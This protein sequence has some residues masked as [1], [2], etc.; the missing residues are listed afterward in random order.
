[1]HYQCS[2][3]GL[4]H[5]EKRSAVECC[6]PEPFPIPDEQVVYCW[7][8]E[9]YGCEACLQRGI[10]DVREL[11]A[12]AAALLRFKEYQAAVLTDATSTA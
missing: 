8:C 12:H 3:C 4:I 1:M 9:G 5:H 11:N 2:E 6:P 7:R 10:L